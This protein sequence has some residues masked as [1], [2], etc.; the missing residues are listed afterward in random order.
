MLVE[1]TIG[2]QDLASLAN[3]FFFARRMEKSEL[4]NWLIKH[5]FASPDTITQSITVSLSMEPFPSAA[6]SPGRELSWRRWG[7]S[8]RMLAAWKAQPPG[9]GLVRTNLCKTDFIFS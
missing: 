9:K 6:R 8:V 4:C 2:R 1:D 5:D 7:G 3:F